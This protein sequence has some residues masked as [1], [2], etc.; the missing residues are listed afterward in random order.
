MCWQSCC[1]VEVHLS[2]FRS[3][4]VG[5]FADDP[6]FCVK[7]SSCVRLGLCL[8]RPACAGHNNAGHSRSA[9]FHPRITDALGS[10]PNVPVDGL[11]ALTCIHQIC[12]TAS[13]TCLRP[14]SASGRLRMPVSACITKPPAACSQPLMFVVFVKGVISTAVCGWTRVH[15]VADH[16][17]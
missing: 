7:P 1:A 14:P 13:P 9:R 2:W 12:T 4:R 16:Q 8:L 11:C 10:H 5:L 17:Q 3:W 6:P 15:L